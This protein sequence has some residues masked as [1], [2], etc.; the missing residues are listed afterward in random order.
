M[1][2]NHERLEVGAGIVEGGGVT[3]TSGAHDHDI[4]YVHSGD[5]L[6]SEP[7]DFASSSPMERRASPPDGRDA[8][9]S[10]RTTGISLSSQR[11]W[12]QFPRRSEPGAGVSSCARPEPR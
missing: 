12:L 1:A 10:T 5:Y 8:R 6:D 3:G 7:T 4:A 2:F 9:L 11:P